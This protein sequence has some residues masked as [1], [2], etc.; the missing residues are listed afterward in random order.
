MSVFTNGAKWMRG[1]FTGSLDWITTANR[2]IQLPDDSGTIQLQDRA[3]GAL[4]SGVIRLSAGDTLRFE[5]YY[6]NTGSTS[7]TTNSAQPQYLNFSR[8]ST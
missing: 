3:I 8:L 2:S 1:A 4:N 6:T 7:T 5:A